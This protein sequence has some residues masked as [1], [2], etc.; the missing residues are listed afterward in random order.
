MT[1]MTRRINLTIVVKVVDLDI[2][3]IYNH[4]HMVGMDKI[5]SSVWLL[6]P[7]AIDVYVMILRM[8][9]LCY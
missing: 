5:S 7:M 9:S 6:K 4:N 3:C 8:G 1:K 2:S